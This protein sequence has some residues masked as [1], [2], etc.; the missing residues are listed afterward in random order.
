MQVA[1]TLPDLR[2]ACAA[3]RAGNRNL[4]LVPT[5]G[6]L[7]EGHRT[8]VRRAVESGAATVASI[9]VNPLQF[10]ASEDL[11]RY[12][13]DEAGDLAALQSAGCALAWL[14]DVETM[15]P[16][17]GATTISLTGPAERWEGDARPGHFRGVATVCAKLF[18]QVRPDRAYFGEKDWQQLQVVRRMVADLLLPLEI[19]GVETVREADGLAL[20]S[21]NRFLTPQERALAAVLPRTMQEAIADLADGRPA[22]PVLAAARE[23]LAA[24]GFAVDYLALVDGPNLA[25]IEARRAGARVVAAARLGSVRLIDNM[26][27]D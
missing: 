21:R 12:P 14:P 6:A 18:G 23:R 1:R 15:Y 22:E 5:M 7:H 4:A 13:R 20:S 3:L 25:P 27:A 17:D 10:G 8:L 11:A 9:F 2:A 26:A 16:P 24:A 19:V